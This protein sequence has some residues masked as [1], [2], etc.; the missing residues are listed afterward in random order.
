M[1]QS[2]NCRMHN[3]LMV[4]SVAVHRLILEEAASKHWKVTYQEPSNSE[5]VLGVVS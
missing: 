1:Q 3:I 2:Y 4:T 5:V